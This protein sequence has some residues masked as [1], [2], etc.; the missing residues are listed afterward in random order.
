VLLYRGDDR[1]RIDR[2][3]CV[4]VEQFLEQLEPSRGLTDGL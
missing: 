3:R 2:V 4:P 1:L